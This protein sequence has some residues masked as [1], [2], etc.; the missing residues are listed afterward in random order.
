MQLDL[1]ELQVMKLLL[2]LLGFCSEHEMSSLNQT[3]AEEE[4][5]NVKVEIN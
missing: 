2:R 3:E 1:C 4:E 5:M